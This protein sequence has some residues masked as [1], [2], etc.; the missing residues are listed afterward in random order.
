[1][2]VIVYILEK[3]VEFHKKSRLM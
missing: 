3:K 1:M 2:L